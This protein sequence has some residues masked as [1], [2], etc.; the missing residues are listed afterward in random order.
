MDECKGLIVCKNRIKYRTDVPI[1]PENRKDVG[2]LAWKIC[3]FEIDA[4]YSR[5]IL[6]MYTTSLVLF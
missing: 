1:S 6:Y 4:S 5:F 3:G 2:C